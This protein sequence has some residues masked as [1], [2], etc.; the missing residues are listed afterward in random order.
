MIGSNA[1]YQNAIKQFAQMALGHGRL[2]VASGEATLDNPLCG[3]RIHIQ[4]AVTA[5][6]VTA[7]A[8]ETRGCLLCQAAASVT[9]LRGIAQ[10]EAGIELALTALEE[11]LKHGSTGSMAWPECSMFEPA[12]AHASRHKCILLPLR[13]LL[14]AFRDSSLS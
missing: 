14:S 9:S 2:D 1:L 4:V 10:D 11:M 7:I 8:H 6:R 13:A 5:G 12:R 3:D